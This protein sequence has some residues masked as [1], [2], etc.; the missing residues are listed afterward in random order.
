MQAI[1]LAAGAGKRLVQVSGGIP[2]AMLRIGRKSII[3]NQIES[4]LEQGVERFVIVIGYKKQ[5][6]REH[7]LQF[8]P[9]KQVTF[10]EN[11]RFSVTN[12][13][14]SLY[15]AKKYFTKPFLYFN[16]DVFYDK[17]LLDLLDLEGEKSQL[18]LKTGECGEEEVKIEMDANNRVL[19]IGKKLPEASCAGEFIGIAYFAGNNLKPFLGCLKEG[20]DNYQENN[21]FE[22]ALNLLCRKYEIEAVPTGDIACIEID[23]PSDLQE[24]ERIFSE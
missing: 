6:L 8:L 4:C 14:Y 1:I 13:L 3:Q 9:P 19:N 17:Q 15:L 24:A 18:L 22:Y 21:F 10:I 23:F 7:V 12:T 11:D 5:M 2:K 16:A 20:I